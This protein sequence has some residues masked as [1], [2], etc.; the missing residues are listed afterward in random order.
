MSQKRLFLLDAFA[1]IYRAHFAFSKNPR[2]NSKG[3]NTKKNLLILVF[4]S[5]LLATPLGT[6]IS[7]NI[8]QTEKHSQKKSLHQ[9]L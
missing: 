2:I 7:Q 1:L 5:T 8:K 9:F 4:A 3:F 6:T